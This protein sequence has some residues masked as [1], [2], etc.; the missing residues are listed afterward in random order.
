MIVSRC[1]MDRELIEK[2]SIGILATVCVVMVTTPRVEGNRLAVERLGWELL[3]EQNG[4]R[5][6]MSIVFL[7]SEEWSQVRK[8]HVLS[9][10]KVEDKTMAK[11]GQW[12]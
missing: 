2:E 3:A 1:A 4:A 12:H 8:H 5:P 11:D 7:S 6:L 9:L 10:R